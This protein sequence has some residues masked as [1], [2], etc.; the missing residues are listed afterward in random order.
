MPSKKGLK[1]SEGQSSISAFLTTNTSS[2]TERSSTDQLS[3]LKTFQAEM[4]PSQN[5]REKQILSMTVNST[6]SER[7]PSVCDT[8]KQTGDH[9]KI[10]DSPQTVVSKGGK[11]I[12]DSWLKI[13]P[14]LYVNKEAHF[15]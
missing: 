6:P 11:K 12:Q 1:I 7:L 3:S 9:S 4:S 10:S 2:N 15:C 8:Q 13:L 5:V 14:W